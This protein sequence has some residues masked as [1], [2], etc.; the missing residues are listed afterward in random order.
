MNKIITKDNIEE[1]DIIRTIDSIKKD[2]IIWQG[3]E[4]SINAILKYFTNRFS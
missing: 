2:V 4:N 1:T 3:S